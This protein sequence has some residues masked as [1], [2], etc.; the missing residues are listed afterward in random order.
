M[1]VSIS[2]GIVAQMGT[3]FGGRERSLTS[4]KIWC[5]ASKLGCTSFYFDVSVRASRR[6]C[7]ILLTMAA[8]GTKRKNEGTIHF[9]SQEKGLCHVLRLSNFICRVD[10]G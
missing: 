5:T 2:A 10:G 7:G 1:G 9:R 6:V 4:S 3:M 8:I